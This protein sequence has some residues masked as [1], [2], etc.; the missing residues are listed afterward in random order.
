M[1]V[2]HLMYLVVE[3]LSKLLN[4][5]QKFMKRILRQLNMDTIGWVIFLDVN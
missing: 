5:F 4:N 3:L 2:I 1:G